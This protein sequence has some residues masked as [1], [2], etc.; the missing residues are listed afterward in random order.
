MRNSSSNTIQK[1]V[2][3]MRTIS[4]ESITQA[5]CDLSIKA[6]VVLRKDIQ[7]ALSD[8]AIKESNALSKF[9]LETL[10]QNAKIAE[11]ENMPMCQDT[12]MAVVFVKI[13][14]AVHIA[15]DINKAINDGIRQGY[16][17][18]YLRASVVGDPIVRKN[19]CDNTPG[20]IHYD[21]VAGDKLEITVAPKGFGSENMGAVRMLTPA[22]GLEGIEDFVVNTVKN[23]GANPCPPIV[24]GV[25]VGGTMEK[26]VL[27]AKEALLQD[28]SAQHTDP[29]WQEIEERL[30]KKI[31]ALQI[32]AAGFGGDTTA[33]A[34]HIKTYPTHIAGLP[35]AVCIGCNAT[36]HETVVL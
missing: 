11:C 32:G 28:L 30:L 18:G 13:G 9:A 31:N 1:S 17:K 19:T 27:L 33:L 16:A 14:H 22:A 4:T 2:D 8:A 23:A 29:M 3:S 26:C 12:G 15:G 36:R 35:V 21:F 5:V 24:V 34:V 6:N 7:S 10:L 20:V 25:G